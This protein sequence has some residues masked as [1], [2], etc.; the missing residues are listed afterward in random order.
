MEGEKQVSEE[1]L[2]QVMRQ[3]S[4]QMRDMLGKLHVAL[5]SIAPPEKRDE[6]EELD[7]LAAEL[8]REF[9][10]L[11]RLANDLA[12]EA[13]PGTSDPLRNRDIVPFCAAL[14]GRIRFAA[15]LLEISVE[16]SSTVDSCVIGFRWDRVERLL[17]NLVSNA[18][19]F[20]PKGGKLRLELDTDQRYVILRVMDTGVGMTEDELHTILTR[21][22]EAY[23]VRMPPYGVGLG[24]PLCRR[25]AREH[26]GELT[27][28][29]EKGV[30]TVV[31]VTLEKKETKIRDLRELRYE[32]TGGF[33]HML[34]E[35][36]DA[37]PAEGYREKY[38]D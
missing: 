21:G 10:R 38:M 3:T 22:V 19:K 12:E 15:E 28:A 23:P 33:D 11:M 29:S 18:L 25:I 8:H 5:E 4:L 34:V 6:D 24:L 13:D 27:I 35:L 20:T 31:T 7:Y 16:F 30:G 26:G 2:R 1:E 14:A 37:I 9:Y 36:S 17:M 32:Y